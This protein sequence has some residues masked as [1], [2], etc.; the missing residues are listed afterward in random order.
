MCYIAVKSDKFAEFLLLVPLHV[1]PCPAAG[2][3]WMTHEDHEEGNEGGGGMRA[4]PWPLIIIKVT[5]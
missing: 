2:S 4:P 3:D 5:P 1:P